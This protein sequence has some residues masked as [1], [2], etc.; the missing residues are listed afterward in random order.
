LLETRKSHHYFHILVAKS[1]LMYYLWKCLFMPAVFLLA[2]M[3]TDCSGK[4]E[5]GTP[6][7][8]VSTEWLQDHLNDPNVVILHSGTA[9][10]FDTLHIPG[11]RLID[12]YHFTINNEMLRNEMLRNEMPHGD[13]IVELLRDVGVDTNSKIVL[14]HENISLLNRTARVFVAL[15]HLGLGEQTM[16]LD[17]GLTAWLEEGY[18]TTDELADFPRGNLEPSDSMELIIIAAEFDPLRWSDQV[19]VIDARSD[20][21]YY[22]TPGTLEEPS[23][24]GHVEGAYSL[25]YLKITTD[26]SPY[27]FRSDTELK[28][29]FRKAGMDHDKET[30]IY[31]NSGI[32]GS[33][34]YLAARHLA[35]PALLYDGSFEE[36]EELDLPST[37]P[38]AIP[39]KN[40]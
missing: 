38:V 16:V 21:E 23:E 24:G 7:I 2:F 40:E 29:L 33:L 1:S 35:Y 6:G 19:V 25:S 27:L 14:Y 5:S 31:C 32:K 36:W 22:G 4:K 39:G 18:E 3:L 11:A 30:L 12:P 20:E 17:G 34:I 13:S 8:L 10:L 15:D 9:A 26:D 37:M 28:E